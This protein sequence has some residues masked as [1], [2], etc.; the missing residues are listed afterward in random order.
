MLRPFKADPALCDD[1]DLSGPLL[2]AF[3]LGSCHLLARAERVSN[4]RVVARSRTP[5][6]PR[7]DGQGELRLHSGVVSAQ[8]ARAELAGEPASRPCAGA[9]SAHLVFVR[10]HSSDASRRAGPGA[11]SL[12]LAPGLQ[13]AA[14]RALL[15]R[16]CVPACKA[17]FC[18]P[19]AC[20]APA[21]S[22]ARRMCRGFTACMLGALA[23]TWSTHT[24]SSLLAAIVPSLEAR[25]AACVPRRRSL[26]LATGTT[27]ARGVPVRAGVRV[28]RAPDA[29]LRGAADGP[30]PPRRADHTQV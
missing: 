26:T 25:H 27:H 11:V 7:A 6:S 4:A 15:R 29:G 23:T 5:R 13:H 28:V 18:A 30:H 2:F 17:R 19:L 21:Q 16:R 14:H 12:R 10:A 8:H 9:R 22:D 1:G 24:A 3:A 20:R